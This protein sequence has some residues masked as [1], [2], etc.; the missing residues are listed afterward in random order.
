[1]RLEDLNIKI[2]ADGADIEEM[3]REYARGN[4]AGFTANPTL[5]KKAGVRDY[6]DFAREAVAAIPAL[7]ISFEVFADDF[8]TME[9]EAEILAGMG[10]NV[11]VKIPITNSKG[12]S[13]IPL[14]HKLS[15]KGIKI[16]VTAVFTLEQVEQAV[17][18]FSEGTSNIVSVFAG[19][20][21]DA[22]VD[23]EPLMKA[24]RA[25]CQKKAGTEL[26]WAS[27]REIFN[28]VQADRCG[29]D[30]ITVT[31]DILD[32]LPCLG[33]EL[34]IFSLETVRMFM[35]DGASLGYSL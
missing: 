16:N 17:K 8:E 26:L 29:T 2:F 12:E 13:S 35:R 32:K 5:M 27:C 25:I 9:K 15:E 6:A 1:M 30:I 34:S 21:M 33:K 24:A 11:F 19:R 10:E 20:I 7:P 23:A 4:V 28:I 14:I 3:K 31:R 18:A 22:G